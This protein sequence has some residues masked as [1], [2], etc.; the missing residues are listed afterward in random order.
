MTTV[1]K[2]GGSLVT[3]KTGDR[4]LDRAGLQMVAKTIGSVDYSDLIIVHGGGSFG[5]PVAKHYGVSANTGTTDSKA[6]AAIS[7]A[8]DELSAAVVQA[9][10]EADV[11]AVG[12][13]TGS[14][15]WLDA[16]GN[17]HLDHGTV[18][19]MLDEAFVPVARGDIVIQQSRG[20]TIV[21]GDTVA[22]GLANVLRGER[23]GLCAD[24][25]GVLDD[26]GNVIP[27]IE[28]YEAVERYLDAPDGAD[29]TGGMATKIQS[30]LA[31]DVTGAIFGPSELDDFL[32]GGF[33]GTRIGP[34]AGS[35]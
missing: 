11:P 19:T 13:K 8:M 5:H 24:V 4:Q 26:T 34:D 9:L 20:A 17:I 7:D 32:A 23:I 2:L 22:V 6:I 28:S 31:S 14:I 33:P 30:I 3:E 35:F 12:I 29:V 27:E 10:C 21:S 16:G 18:Q 1:L 15:A 25:P